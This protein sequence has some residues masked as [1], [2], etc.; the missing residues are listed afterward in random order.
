MIPTIIPIITIT[1]SS[2][3]NVPTTAALL[4][5]IARL[6]PIS[7]VL[8]LT[9]RT[10]IIIKPNTPITKAKKLKSEKNPQVC[11]LNLKTQYIDYEQS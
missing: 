9:L 7:L 5:P 11:E 3:A 1:N 8:S 6:I 2:K 10:A 4:N